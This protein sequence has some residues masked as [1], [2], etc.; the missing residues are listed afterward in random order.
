MAR[1]S[2]RARAIPLGQKRFLRA[3]RF[4]PTHAVAHRG[5]AGRH[6]LTVHADLLSQASSDARFGVGELDALGANPAGP[7]HEAALRIDE[8]DMMRRPRQVV[9]RPLSARSHATRAS[10]TATT[11]VTGARRDVQSESSAGCLPPRPSSQPETPTSPESTYNRGA[12]P[13]VLPCWLHIKREH[14]PIQ[15]GHVVSLFFVQAAEQTAHPKCGP[16]RWPGN[17]HFSGPDR[18]QLEPK[19]CSGSD[20]WCSGSHCVVTAHH[21]ERVRQIA[22][23]IYRPGA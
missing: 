22:A 10:T 2:P 4:A 7:T 12:I 20:T 1:L 16:R 3:P 14:H 11:G 5:M 19:H 18:R 21:F 17:Y 13:P 23:T 6:R 8:R 9:P 15:D